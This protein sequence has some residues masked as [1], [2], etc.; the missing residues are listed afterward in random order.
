[1]VEGGSETAAAFLSNALVNKVTFYYAPKIIGGRE[2][3]AAIGGAVL[4]ASRMPWS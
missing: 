4:N 1:M 2:A 3:I